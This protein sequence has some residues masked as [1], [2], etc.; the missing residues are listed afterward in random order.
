MVVEVVDESGG[1]L[2]GVVIEETGGP[3]SSSVFYDSDEAGR[4]LVGGLAPSTHT[5]G[6][7][8]TKAGRTTVYRELDVGVG[9]SG[10]T[11][12]VPTPFLT[13]IDD[14]DVELQPSVEAT[15]GVEGI[16]LTVPA[17]AVTT[18][19]SLRA[20]ALAPVELP[21][22]LPLGWSPVRALWLDVDSGLQAPLQVDVSLP[23]PLPAGTEVVW[24]EWDDATY[25]WKVSSQVSLTSGVDGQTVASFT[26]TAPGLTSTAFALVLPDAE[27]RPINLSAGDPLPATSVVPSPLAALSAV[28]AKIE[29]EW[30]AAS[31]DP[32]QVTAAGEVWL[33]GSEPSGSLVRGPLTEEYRTRNGGF[34]RSIRSWLT[35]PTHRYPSATLA[36]EDGS[37]GRFPIRPAKVLDPRILQG[38]HQRFEVMPVVPEE[39]SPIPATGGF[40]SDGAVRV[41]VPS[42]IGSGASRVR[43][44]ELDPTENEAGG[45]RAVQAFELDWTGSL[46]TNQSIDFAPSVSSEAVHFV[47]AERIEL[48][49]TTGWHPVARYERLTDGRLALDEPAGSEGLRGIRD[50]GAYALFP[51][52]EL[53]GVVEGTVSN[54][55]GSARPDV[56]VRVVGSPWLAVSGSSG[57]Y[58][59]LAP[60]GPFTVI[61]EDPVDFDTGSGTGTVSDPWSPVDVDLTIQPEAPS[62]VETHPG[63]GATDVSVLASVE[64]VFTEPV[65]TSGEEPL[66]LREEASGES[67]P[68]RSRVADEGRRI[69]FRP[70]VELTIS[71]TYEFVVDPLLEDT[72][73][74]ALTGSTVFEFT[75]ESPPSS[76]LS[77]ARLLSY[78]P[79][80]MTTPCA[81]YDPAL[82][83]ADFDPTGNEHGVPGYSAVDDTITCVVGNAGV[84]EPNSTVIVVNETTGRT[85]TVQSNSNGAFKTFVAAGETDLLSATI[86]N[87]NGTEVIVPLEMQI[88]DDGSVALYGSGGSIFADNPLGGEPLELIVE[89]G[90]IPNRTKIKM[91]GLTTN[92]FD[93]RVDG[94]QPD[95]GTALLSVQVDWSG[96]ELLEP[97]DVRFPISEPDLQLAPGETA[98]ETQFAL[99]QALPIEIQGESILAYETLDTM[100]Y[101][102]GALATH[103]YPMGGLAARVAQ[104][105][106]GIVPLH[107]QNAV[108]PSLRTSRIL[109]VVKQAQPGVI[110][111]YALACPP[112][113][114]CRVTPPDN[115]TALNAQTAEQLLP[116]GGRVLPGAVVFGT[117]ST[118]GSPSSQIRPGQT[119]AVANEEGRF[120]LAA[121]NGASGYALTAHHPDYAN[122][123]GIGAVSAGDFQP[124][125]AFSQVTIHARNPESE[126]RRLPRVEASVTPVLPEVYVDDDDSPE[127]REE[128]IALV[129]VRV[130]SLSETPV[131]VPTWTDQRMNTSTDGDIEAA[132]LELVGPPTVVASGAFSKTWQFKFTCD[133]EGLVY[134]RFVGDVDGL[135]GETRLPVRFGPP[136]TGPSSDEVAAR[137]NDKTGPR[138]IQ[139]FP[140]QDSRS[141]TSGSIRLS[142]SEPVRKTIEDGHNWYSIVP[143]PGELPLVEV[144]EAQSEVSMSW[145]E[146]QPETYYTL[147]VTNAVRDIAGIPL[148]QKPSTKQVKEPF[149]LRFRTSAHVEVEDAFREVQFGGGAV[150]QGNFAYLL[151]RGARPDRALKIYSLS[152]PTARPIYYDLGTGHP[153]SLTVVEDFSYL[154]AKSRFS[155]D[156][157]RNPGEIEGPTVFAGIETCKAENRTLLL[158]AGSTVRP[159]RTLDLSTTF[160]QWLHVIDITRGNIPMEVVASQVS[161]APTSVVNKV[162]W[163]PPYVGFKEISERTSV[164]LVDLATFV[165]LADATPEQL[166]TVP[167]I[168]V[169]RPGVDANADGDFVDISLGDQYPWLGRPNRLGFAGRQYWDI[170]AQTTQEIQD[171]SIS[172][173]SSAFVGALLLPGFHLQADGRADTGRPIG[174]SYRTLRQDDQRGLPIH[175][176]PLPALAQGQ[177]ITTLPS[178]NFDPSDIPLSP[179]RAPVAILSLSST[180]SAS[181]RLLVLDIDDP[182]DPKVIGPPGGIPVP[183]SFG[184]ALSITKDP[185]LQNVAFMATDR[186]SVQL[187]L[188]KLTQAQPSMANHP[189]FISKQPKAG[190]A[191]YDTG[192]TNFGFNVVNE[193]NRQGLHNSGPRLEFVQFLGGDPLVD[194]P[195]L[196]AENLSDAELKIRLQDM[197]RP[198]GLPPSRV[199]EIGSEPSDLQTANRLTH[200]HVMVRASGGS[201][202]DDTELPLLLEGLNAHGGPL[203]NGVIGMAPTRAASEDTLAALDFTPGPE[204]PRVPEVKARRLSDDPSSS[205]YNVYLSPPIALVMDR[206]SEEDLET[207]GFAGATE[208]VILH[209]P[210]FLRASIDPSSTHDAYEAFKSIVDDDKT[211]LLGSSIQAPAMAIPAIIGPNPPVPGG[212]RMPNTSGYMSA[213]TRDF[214]FSEVDLSVPSPWRDLSAARHYIGQNVVSGAFGQ[215][216]E[217]VHEE[218][219]IAVGDY[220]RAQQT[221][222]LLLD[223]VG[224]DHDEFVEPGD[225][226][227]FSGSGERISYERLDSDDARIASHYDSD[228]LLWDSNPHGYFAQ[229]DVVDYYL[230]RT[231]GYYDALIRLP[232]GF[233]RVTPSGTI[234]YYDNSGLLSEVDGRHADNVQIIARLRNGQVRRVTEEAVS[235]ERFLEYGYFR[236]SESS[237]EFEEELDCTT[238]AAAKNGRVCRVKDHAGR[239]VKYDYDGNGRLIEVE[240]VEV[241]DSTGKGFTG[242]PLT[243][244]SWTLGKLTGVIRPASSDVAHVRGT[245]SRVQDPLSGIDGYNGATTTSNA[246]IDA[247]DLPSTP[248]SF[249]LPD[250]SNVGMQFNARA[251]PKSITSSGPNSAPTTVSITYEDKTRIETLTTP[252]GD[253]INLTYPNTGPLRSRGNIVTRTV[254]P[255]DSTPSRSWTYEY[256][257]LFNRLDLETSSAGLETDYKFTSDELDLATIEHKSPG[258]LLVE[259][260]EFEAHGLQ[261]AH[262]DTRGR[263]RRAAYDS[264]TLFPTAVMEGT[265]QTDGF[266]VAY[267]YEGRSGK[268]GLPS[269]L[270][271]SDGTTPTLIIYDEAG[272]MVERQRGEQTEVSAY[273]AEGR[274]VFR[275]Q[276]LVPAGLGDSKDLIVERTYDEGGFLEKE[277]TRAVETWKLNQVDTPVDLATRYEPTHDGRVQQITHPNGLV[278]AFE[279]DHLDRVTKLTSTGSSVPTTEVDFDDAKREK[280][281]TVSLG[282]DTLETTVKFNAFG[283]LESRTRPDGSAEA[284]DYFDDGA[285]RSHELED[286]QNN[287]L[288]SR[289]IATVDAQGRPTTWTLGGRANWTADYIA[290]K[291]THTLA[292]AFGPA[293]HVVDFDSTGRK[294]AVDDG[295]STFTYDYIPNSN[296]VRRVDTL[297]EGRTTS[298]HQSFDSLGRIEHREDDAG[299]IVASY[300]YRLD[301]APV[302]MTVDPDQLALESTAEYSVLGE[303]LESSSPLGT[304]LLMGYDES[305]LESARGPQVAGALSGRTHQYDELG[306]L[307]RTTFRDGTSH[308]FSDFHVTSRARTVTFSSGGGRNYTFDPNGQPTTH[309]VNFG[310]YQDQAS[311]DYD[312][313]GR[314]RS[315]QE[316]SSP[317]SQM[318]ASYDELGAMDS[319]SQ[320]MGSTTETIGYATDHNGAVKR[321][322][323]PSSRSVDVTRSAEGRFESMTALGHG[324]P[325]A[326]V[327]SHATAT[328]PRDTSVGQVEISDQYDHRDR[329]VRRVIMAQGVVLEDIRYAYDTA[330]RLLARQFVTRGGQTDFFAYDA[331]SRLVRS[332][333][334]ARPESDIES[335]PDRLSTSLALGLDWRPGSHGHELVYGDND[336]LETV[337]PQTPAR[338]RAPP[339]AAQQVGYTLGRP[340]S[341][342]GQDTLPDGLGNLTQLDTTAGVVGPVRVSDLEYDGL[343]RLRKV[344][345]SD[346]SMVVLRYRPDG[347]L[348]R[349]TVTC[350]GAPSPCTAT[351]RRYFYSGLQL[352]EVHDVQAS[353]L[354]ARYYYADDEVPLAADLWDAGAQ[355]LQPYAFLTDHAGSVIGLVD[356][357]GQRVERVRYDT[358]GRPVVEA[359]DAAAPQVAQVLYDGND[360][361]VVFTEPVFAPVDELVPQADITEELVELEY[362]LQ[363]RD[364]TNTP[365]AGTWAFDTDVPGTEANTTLTFTPSAPLDT[366]KTH[367]LHIPPGAL[368][369]DWANDAAL[370]LALP[371]PSAG[372]YTGPAAGSTAQP[373]LGRSTTPNELFFQSH[374]WVA[375]AGLYHMKA[376]AYDPSTGLFLQRDPVAYLD[377]LNLYAGFANDP[378]NNTD[379]TGRFICGGFCT[380]AIIGAGI[381]AYAQLYDLAANGNVRSNAEI[382]EGLAIGAGAG[383]VG[384]AAGGVAAAGAVRAGFGTIATGGVSGAAAGGAGGSTARA[385]SGEEVTAGTFLLDSSIGFGIGVAFGTASAIS[386]AGDDI[387]DDVTRAFD[388]GVSAYADE[389]GRVV[390]PKGATFGQSTSRD[391]RKTFFDVNP[392]TKGNVVVHHAVEQQTLVRHPGVV[393]SSEIHSLPNLRGIPKAVNSDIHLSQIRKAWNRFYKQNPN[394]TKQQLLDQATK[395]DDLFGH[396][397]DPPVR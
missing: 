38:A 77:R 300:T 80:A 107:L 137:P 174:A 310:S 154:R 70:D 283:E 342:D 16:D 396:L 240:G 150:V 4:A 213:V 333:L 34:R 265:P 145:S 296:L 109:T 249:G 318:I 383:V 170:P 251:L 207:F 193:G 341:V 214:D 89:P 61:A 9:D 58:R 81:P 262:T 186:G 103:S 344:Q 271:Y 352:M 48:G 53:Q 91:I 287:L 8:F 30:Q 168:L 142:F 294:T 161:M 6:W 101:E 60:P 78:A 305:R 41:H 369:D 11:L 204:M 83:P 67:V 266:S 85:S 235:A 258:S 252:A 97:A 84:A 39:A 135:R 99:T 325:I 385:L 55:G 5:L 322:D 196:A 199:R 113:E 263:V 276:K 156:C 250:G 218:R 44:R 25:A 334:A 191:F 42:G 279:Y 131:T 350:G 388:K 384:A 167:D 63:D 362:L 356:D 335:S 172:G 201:V 273:D 328:A 321:I 147:T 236:P 254:Q 139:S 35:I 32:A 123:E 20:E 82:H 373:R 230:P 166:D 353:R 124:L 320:T 225:V 285:L 69:I 242:R 160:G 119:I 380:A 162:R 45:T 382:A 90:A 185:V 125:I 387:A 108:S 130:S 148:D 46:G 309:S 371:A 302:T 129:N 354:I 75:T 256:D 246:S 12:W 289:S 28:R 311:F 381:A 127:P 171:F 248:L 18:A 163:S 65:S 290:G 208:R 241:T 367:T 338:A 331:D 210:D 245:G 62:V 175:E 14:V 50:R 197:V 190:A 280:K 88:F 121:Q 86:I 244:Y 257:P 68:G 278:E 126:Q 297:E 203:A 17:A 176:Y 295:L 87:Q 138:V 215:G 365:L 323:Y 327:T 31:T 184:Q 159:D 326:A 217:S 359:K 282:P 95:G 183:E 346:G 105:S 299:V 141:S 157:D 393:S 233:V 59:I 21:R 243:K 237:P 286:A 306:R 29:P 151:D 173:P 231:P 52:S 239:V 76:N 73:G 220:V 79:A 198:S 317:S 378:I 116:E 224:D 100:Q 24:A 366:T 117:T 122:N 272:K 307:T 205:F 316:T 71:T 275:S 153:R 372:N 232:G 330:D 72:S 291:T 363:F 397:F 155:S 7:L 15:Y 200:F 212:P 219:I 303:E 66:T 133:R 1:P 347:A 292:S 247:K 315:A 253:V 22:F 128:E 260:L 277:T 98:A 194:P 40:V 56:V 376:R 120:S 188:T 370:T 228:E 394:P 264:D 270:T 312:A 111:G 238:T 144:S 301:D 336:Q 281:I 57:G 357:Q 269:Q 110:M 23:E 202:S 337:S 360:V 178:Q 314:L 223:R 74:S 140:V 164:S 37:S 229:D 189:V 180:V 255:S 64:V 114:D 33:A 298:M 27:L 209:S 364:H 274:E 96:D 329:L 13:L 165:L 181:G 221:D 234:F 134:F 206:M 149:V 304:T 49:G 374:L 319:I 227:L 195:A 351:D 349:K 293:T 19:L 93:Q 368:Q 169:P 389:A 92:E 179:T 313:L 343:A 259:Q 36:S 377:A 104:L 112:E 358:F 324:S 332:E 261:T 216:F 143:D 146:L 115:P 2:P 211:L 47:L 222:L 375:D 51:V 94:V 348:I 386:R 118:F 288:F 267:A 132:T 392:S 102:E 177:R 391:Y 192:Q 182:M 340:S 43:L 268:L 390:A 379:P 26:M 339:L 308:S 226:I 187:D 10:R 361:H 284:F 152:D 106:T 3:T 158:V 355:A 395:I 345:S 54:T 136:D